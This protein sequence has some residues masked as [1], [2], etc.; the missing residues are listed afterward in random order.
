MVKQ[1]F[2]LNLIRKSLSL[3]STQQRNYNKPIEVEKDVEFDPLNWDTY[4]GKTTETVY[5]KELRTY[6]TTNND[7]GF[8]WDKE[9]DP[10]RAGV[11]DVF[12]TKMKFEGAIVKPGTKIGRFGGVSSKNGYSDKDGKRFY[13]ASDLATEKYKQRGETYSNFIRSYG[14]VALHEIVHH[15]H[16]DFN[17]RKSEDMQIHFNQPW[18][19]SHFGQV[20]TKWSDSEKIRL[21]TLRAKTGGL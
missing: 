3:G 8:D 2:F 4:D 13:I 17:Y 12:N 7:S 1:D 20:K 21:K 19:S 16:Y 11:F 6:I 5:E 14:G 10:Y 15:F 9:G 18:S